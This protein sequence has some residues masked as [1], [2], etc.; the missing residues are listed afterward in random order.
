M[1][2]ESQTSPDRPLW[3]VLHDPTSDTRLQDGLTGASAGRVIHGELDQYPD[4]PGGYDG[5][6]V[7]VGAGFWRWSRWYFQDLARQLKPGGILVV[8]D[9]PFA[10][11]QGGGFAGLAKRCLRSWFWG[12]AAASGGLSLQKFSMPAAL[13]EQATVWG[14]NMVAS[15]EVS[16]FP[17]I[18][19]RRVL[20]RK[21]E[22][23]THEPE[24][25]DS[26]QLDRLFRTHFGEWLGSGDPAGTCDQTT[27]ATATSLLPAK[28]RGTVLVLSPHP[29]DELIGCG[30]TLLSLGDVGAF[31]HVVQ[32]TEG[33]TCLALRDEPAGFS[34]RIRWQEAD[35]V[36]NRLGFIC[37]YWETGESRTLEST[38]AMTARIRALISDLQPTLVFIPAATDLHPEHRLANR[39]FMAAGGELLRSCR[40]LEY[41]VW[42]FLPQCD[43]G[44]DVTERYHEVLDALYLYRTAMK[45]EDYVTRCRVLATF[46]GERLL[47]SRKYSVEVFRDVG[48]DISTGV[49]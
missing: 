42:G 38:E 12:L 5:L 29:D 18:G 15:N 34:R 1:S 7:M 31:I 6:R 22:A 43:I 41:P 11:K 20:F 47:A 49:V 44:V 24:A 39:L 48:A 46:Y 26:H 19:G 27:V 45:A 8:E 25:L 10:R 21:S 13:L 36:A 30:G 4:N 14:L 33:L 40:V 28:A 9:P 3:L 37:H 23:P 17:G 16:D 35:S 32:M 2:K